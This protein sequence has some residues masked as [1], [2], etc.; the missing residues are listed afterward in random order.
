MLLPKLKKNQIDRYI[1]A[2]KDTINVLYINL[3]TDLFNLSK[4][5]S[6]FTIS[7]IS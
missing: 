3:F 6:L 2:H 1:A 7:L 4:I 5:F